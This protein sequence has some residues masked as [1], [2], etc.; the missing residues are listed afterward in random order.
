MLGSSERKFE[1]RQVSDT[2]DNLHTLRSVP[3]HELPWIVNVDKDVE[4][5][6]IKG[7]A[8]EQLLAMLVMLDIYT[9]GPMISGFVH[10]DPSS[11]EKYWEV[12][13]V[14]HACSSR[15]NIADVDKLL[16]ETQEFES[17]WN[18][19]LLRK[20]LRDRRLSCMSPEDVKELFKLQERLLVK[21]ETIIA[22]IPIAEDNPMCLSAQDKSELKKNIQEVRKEQAKLAK[23]MT[24]IDIARKVTLGLLVA[25]CAVFCAVAAV[26]TVGLITTTILSAGTAAAAAPIVFGGLFL[27]AV[28]FGLCGVGIMLT[29]HIESN[30]KVNKYYNKQKQRRHIESKT[31]TQ[32]SSTDSEYKLVSDVPAKKG[33]TSTKGML[34]VGLFRV[35][36]LGT[37]HAVNSEDPKLTY[38]RQH[39]LNNQFKDD[40]R[41]ISAWINTPR[42][43]VRR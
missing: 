1:R 43:T 34:E 32:V 13:N 19:A 18:N 16:N 25:G 33:P 10:E 26:A 6:Y 22:G 39:G 37:N 15:P 31:A 28:V 23:D 41:N 40:N 9:Q 29:E 14:I 2:N 21:L 30:H 17:E 11:M 5:D 35:A 20:W 24:N 12:K 27:A 3:H 36:T 7:T 42:Q 4:L 38:G 8:E